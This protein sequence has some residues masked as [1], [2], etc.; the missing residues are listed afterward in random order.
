LLRLTLC[1]A[2]CLAVE[3]Q[4]AE[5]K[6]D[7]GFDAGYQWLHDSNL[8]RLT[9]GLSPAPGGTR[10]PRDDT[11][12][13]GYVGAYFDNVLSRQHFTA[14]AEV[15]AFRNGTY[16][17]LDYD[18][19]NYRAQW[20]WQAGSRLSGILGALRAQQG[21]PFADFAFTS[22]SIN[23]YHTEFVSADLTLPSHLAVGVGAARVASRF[24]DALSAAEEYDERSQDV[25]L[26]LR[27]SA[28]SRLTLAVRR[29][30]AK[31][32]DRPVLQISDNAY[33]QTDVRLTGHV[34]LTDKTALDGY[35]GAARRR[36]PNV[37]SRDYSGPIGRLDFT[38][39]PTAK[40]DL[41]A[42]VRRELGAKEDIVETFVVTTATEARLAWK[43]RTKLSI[44]F[45]LGVMSRDFGGDAGF[46]IS[47]R[48]GVSERQFTQGALLSYQ[49][50]R[51][52]S[53]FAAAEHESRDA[54][55]ATKRY[56]DFVY[57]AGV[58]LKL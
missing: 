18:A 9:D 2:S 7:F 13:S 51:Q 16:D 54:N 25:H 27:S 47:T 45:Q 37:P 17:Y 57:R 28:G 39:S 32:V 52:L 8:F 38:W 46:G 30:K 58:T 29:A 12:Q 48:T 23:T 10:G 19:K 3:A 20:D 56:A 31:Y 36:F 5:R 21:R 15:R 55:A 49:P 35:V 4:A 22:R 53:V 34:D 41:S 24:S 1:F 43:L 6:G 26:T 42:A 14:A 40:F 33:D 44:A 50:W 11:V